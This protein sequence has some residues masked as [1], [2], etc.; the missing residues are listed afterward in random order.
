MLKYLSGW[1]SLLAYKGTLL[2][3]SLVIMTPFMKIPKGVKKK[4]KKRKVHY[5]T[6]T[7]FSLL[8]LL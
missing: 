6:F 7:R 4:E 5:F 3:W 1:I 8:N 2:H